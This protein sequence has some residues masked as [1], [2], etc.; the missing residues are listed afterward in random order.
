MAKKATG[1]K[2]NWEKGDI[3]ITK[4]PPKKTKNKGIK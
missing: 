2:F 3:T 4:T 1:G